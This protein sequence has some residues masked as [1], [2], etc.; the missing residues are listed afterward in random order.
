MPCKMFDVWE[1]KAMV[2]I[3]KDWRKNN[4]V[5]WKQFIKHMFWQWLEHSTTTQ[6]HSVFVLDLGVSVN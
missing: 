1:T 6:T 5:G 4:V 2:Q 3:A